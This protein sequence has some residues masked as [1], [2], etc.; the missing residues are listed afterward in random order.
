MART[1]GI[2]LG[3]QSFELLMLEGGAKKPRIAQSALGEIAWDEDDPVGAASAAIKEA[4]KHFKKKPD[5]IHVSIDAG[6]AAFRSLTVPFEEKEK[7]ESVLKF[8]VESQLP[9]WDIEEVVCDFHV[10]NSTGVESQLLVTAV[11][12]DDLWGAINSAEKAGFEPQEIELEA[13]SV[14]N[15]AHAKGVFHAD[16]ASLLVYVGESSTSISVIDG[17]QLRGMRAMHVGAMETLQAPAEGADAEGLD[18]PEGLGGDEASE[19]PEQPVAVD[20]SVRLAQ[21]AARLRRELTRAR[22]CS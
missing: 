5:A 4:G 6:M 17:G 18:Q 21:V 2:R 9:Q 14:L 12:K 15:A 20:S 10:L 11:Q 8:E 13:A 3:A 19:A 1:L 22:G 16:E 7:I